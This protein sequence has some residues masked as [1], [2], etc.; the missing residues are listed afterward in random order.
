V[1]S[2]KIPLVG[3]NGKKMLTSGISEQQE[4]NSVTL[5]GI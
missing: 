3:G 5:D 1:G 4:E 2:G